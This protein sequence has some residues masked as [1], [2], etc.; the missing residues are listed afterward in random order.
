MANHSKHKPVVSVVICSHGRSQ[1]LLRCLQK[2]NEQTRTD[3]E[4]IVIRPVADQKN[5]LLQKK[6]RF[7]L[8]QKTDPAAD[9]VQA[10]DLGWRTAQAP[11]VAWLDDDV[12]VPSF[13]IENV[14]TIFDDPSIGGITG[15]TIIPETLLPKRAVFFW[16]NPQW[17]QLPL[18]WVWKKYVLENQ[19]EKVAQL[20]KTGWWS[21]GSN[22]R[23]CLDKPGIWEAD[24]LEACNMVVRKL[25]VTKVGG[26]DLTYQ[27]T[28]E[29]CE[30][31]LALAIKKTSARLV[32]TRQVGVVHA[33]SQS[34]VFSARYSLWH[35]WQ[36][37]W[38]FRQK[39]LK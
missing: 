33:V 19:P 31:D 10:R 14:V 12:L 26:F 8:T 1:A 11:L 30:V 24:Y 34:G 5:N 39:W 36:N 16:I 35:R 21:P 2:L 6:Y 20:Y 3:F 15:P 13:W 25:L 28:S 23:A 4:V 29:W 9:L 37:Y 18:A 7:K 32:W 38:Y 17:W 27:K 22:F